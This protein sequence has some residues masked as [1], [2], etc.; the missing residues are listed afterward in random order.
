MGLRSVAEP[1]LSWQNRDFIKEGLQQPVPPEAQVLPHRPL[2]LESKALV[3]SSVHNL[4]RQLRGIHCEQP[5]R[6]DE[7]RSSLSQ[8]EPDDR[9]EPRVGH[10]D[11]LTHDSSSCELCYCSDSRETIRTASGNE[12]DEGTVALAYPGPRGRRRDVGQ[13]DDLRNAGPA[14]TGTDSSKDELIL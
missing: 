6:I 14:E 10:H 8:S 12:V 4:P 5:V 7:R 1:E 2:A 3:E 9:V 11:D 13:R